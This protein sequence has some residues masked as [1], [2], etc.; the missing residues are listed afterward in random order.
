[1]YGMELVD[2]TVQ[3]LAGFGVEMASILGVTV[4]G[5]RAGMVRGDERRMDMGAYFSRL[6]AYYLGLGFLRNF[7]QK[8][9]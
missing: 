1:M 5:N 6:V 4:C 9:S 3:Y 2:Y 8:Q 7:A